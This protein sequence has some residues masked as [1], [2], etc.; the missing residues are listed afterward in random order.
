M[1]YFDERETE[2]IVQ[3]DP[4]NLMEKI[5][6]PLIGFYDTGEVELYNGLSGCRLVVFNLHYNY[7]PYGVNIEADILNC[8]MKCAIY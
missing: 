4:T 7:R 3:P 2:V 1:G 8:F 5:K 6:V